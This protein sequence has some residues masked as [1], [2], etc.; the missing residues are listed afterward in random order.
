MNIFDVI[1]IGGGLAGLT[2]S[3]YL[4]REGKKV[5]VLEKSDLIGGRAITTNKN[6]IL[7]NLGA[8]A[9][10][11]GGEAMTIL[12]ELGISLD[13]GIPS[14]GAHGLWKNQ[15]F[16][17]PTDLRSLLS[18]SLLSVTG[19][20]TFIRLMMKLRMLDIHTIP[21][22]SLSEWTEK[23]I[24]DPLVR[25]IFYALC[26]TTTYTY[27]PKVQLARP[28]LKQI[29]LSLKDGVFYVDGGWGSLVTKLRKKAEEAGAAFLHHQNVIEVDPYAQ[30]KRVSCSNGELFV[31]SSVILAVSPS[32]AY[33][34]I[35]GA[36]ATPL[37]DW[38]EQA[39]PI[40]AACLDLGLKS[41]PQ[42]KHQF[43]LGLDQPLFFTNQSREAKLSEDGTVVV[44]L[45]KYHNPAV[46]SCEPEAD[47]KHLE[48]MMD[49]IQPGWQKKVR[50]KQY[51]PKMTVVHDFPLIGRLIK[52]G[53]AI[54]QVEGLY[55]AGDWAGHDELLADA[56]AAS[57]KRAAMHIIKSHDSK[58][59]LMDLGDR[60][61]LSNV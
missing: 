34:L 35:K 7:M 52:P 57:G 4:A 38:K 23:E 14:T 20:I 50:E 53:P 48:H 3:T 45:I 15:V 61:T 51:L 39:R 36:E 44:S 31:A 13:G 8:H 2:A 40:T 25:H 29:Q 27:A 56:A 12:N 5:L 55:A 49:L 33:K 59:R 37:H 24:T 47:R 19:K 21:A 22:I 6:G 28:V 54:E 41:L 9:L 30:M 16:K 17:I 60:T 46:L 18:S 32:E 26:R 42:P 1:I 43:V 58:E 11:R 10:Y